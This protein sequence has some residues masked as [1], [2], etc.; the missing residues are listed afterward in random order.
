[1]EIAP[2]PPQNISIGESIQA[3]ITGLSVAHAICSISDHWQ[4]LAF[5]GPGPRDMTDR[6]L[7]WIFRHLVADYPSAYI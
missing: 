1:M 4:A 2:W 5:T 6:D 3:M 7:R